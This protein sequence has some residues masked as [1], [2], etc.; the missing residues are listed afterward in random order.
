MITQSQ[1]ISEIKPGK[2]V[3]EDQEDPLM[4]QTC[5]FNCIVNIYSRYK[6]NIKFSHEYEVEKC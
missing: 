5:P 2:S 3:H 1:T 4:M 6:L